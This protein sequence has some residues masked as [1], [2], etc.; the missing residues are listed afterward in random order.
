LSKYDRQITL[1]EVGEIGQ[2]K[3]RNANV[4]VVGAGGLGCPV[5]QYLTAAGIGSIGIVDGDFVSE[6]NLHRQILFGPADIGK[7]KAELAAL[8]L[9]NQN[10]DVHFNVITDMLIPQNAAEIIEP[11]EIVV[12]CT[13]QI[14]TRYLI[15]DTCVLLGKALVYG[16]IHTFE[17]QVS[18]FNFKNGANY[19][20]LFPN[21]P[22]PNSVPNCNETGVLG[23]LPG[24]IGTMQ[25]NEVLK[26]ILGYGE[27]LSGKLFWFSAKHNS[28]Q[29]IQFEKQ[30]HN[31]QVPKTI[32]ELKALDYFS[33]CNPTFSIPQNHG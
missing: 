10:P 7:P 29:T 28:S 1:K 24:I 3:L 13:D 21:P 9:K 15:N 30:A 5:L 20:D 2:Q 31:K 23:V 16:A 6:S 8:V 12:D 33:Y 22:K 26:I 25:A 11:F 17:G 4:L 18:V 19:R 32:E 14:H 27:V